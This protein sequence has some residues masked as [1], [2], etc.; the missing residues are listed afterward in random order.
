MCNKCGENCTCDPSLH[1]V[2]NSLKWYK[3]P[4]EDVLEE[5]KKLREDIDDLSESL[6][7]CIDKIISKI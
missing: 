4:N 1:E 2:E 7:F 3:N 5:L 6:I